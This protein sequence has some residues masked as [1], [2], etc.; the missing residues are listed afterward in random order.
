MTYQ[1]ITVGRRKY[2]VGLLWQP[3]G[4]GYTPRN[5]ARQ[6][7]RGIDKKL[8]LYTDY[9]A[10]I[11]LGARRGGMRA[12]MPSAAAG[13]VDAF[14]EFSSFLAV[15]KV[16]GGYYLV[17]V[18]NGVIL[19]DKLFTDE[20]QARARYVALS[21]IPDWGAFFAPESWAM[22]R[23]VERRI[24]DILA[25]RNR[26][27]LH[28]ISR[29]RANILSL[30]LI[31]GFIFVL[32][33]FFRTPIAQMVSPRPQI[34]TINPELAAEYKRQIEAKNK[35]LDAQFEVERNIPAPPPPLVM[36]Y[37]HL[38]DVMARAQ[39]CYQAI[40]FLMQPI[41]GWT[42]TAAE[43]GEEYA[44]VTF[45]RSFGT[46][47]EFYAVATELMPG[48]FVVE[49]SDSGIVVRARLPQVPRAAS[50]DERDADTVLRDVTTAFQG[51]DT[52]IEA[53]VVI[54]TLSNGVDTANLMVVEIAASSKLTP[55]AFSE[56]FQE[57]SGV[58]MT[59]CAWNAGSKTWN[60]EVII[61][62][63]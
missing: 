15:F 49:T 37:D 60:Y 30:V 26:G 4:V 2:A 11:G 23:A 31:G 62:A 22:P 36:P 56:I 5:Y 46:L 10:M 50:Q 51:I 18:R 55:M 13:V 35:E 17:A 33:Y 42:Q 24:E 9:R 12:G 3:M 28:T 29:A 38:P 21:Q 14:G 41:P 47:G 20:A 45:A 32:L 6:L 27:I 39:V 1:Y 19:E 34:S 44:S 40:G 48:A 61:Y 53:D 54:D 43:C 59:R 16:S 58:Y 7:A 25:G 57:F 52:P 8:N 63:K